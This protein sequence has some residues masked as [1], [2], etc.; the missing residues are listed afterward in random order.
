MERLGVG[1]MLCGA[2]DGASSGPERIGVDFCTGDARKAT[3][4]RSGGPEDD[5]FQRL[6]FGERWTGKQ[7]R[8]S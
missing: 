6:W 8:C 5:K 3:R 1:R 4:N 7:E 2:Q